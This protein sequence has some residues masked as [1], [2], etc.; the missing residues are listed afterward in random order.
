MRGASATRRVA[1]GVVF[2]FGKPLSCGGWWPHSYHQLV[3]L[4]PGELVPTSFQGPNS[5]GSRIHRSM[6]MD[7]HS[8]AT[9]MSFTRKKR[10][11]SFFP[12]TA[13]YLK[14]CGSRSD[15]SQKRKGLTSRNRAEPLSF[16]SFMA[17]LL[18]PNSRRALYADR[19][20]TVDCCVGS[21]QSPQ[22]LTV[23]RLELSR[24]NAG[25]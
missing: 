5:L 15:L 9:E 23:L 14:E 6:A 10:Q 11:L 17:E 3:I 20:L 21:E 1:I 24:P 16:R 25:V 7:C 12:L 4:Q 22:W 13:V 8:V 19:Q 2:L 18:H